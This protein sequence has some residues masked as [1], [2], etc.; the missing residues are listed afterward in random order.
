MSTHLIERMI[1]TAKKYNVTIFVMRAPTSLKLEMLTFH[2][3]FAKNKR[4]HNSS[5]VMHCL[6]DN[7]GARTIGD[8]VQISS[9]TVPAVTKLGL[10][11]M[12]GGKDCRKKAK[13]LLNRIEP[14][15]KPD[16][17]TP[18]STIYGTHPGESEEIKGKTHVWH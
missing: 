12:K 14:H 5:R 9:G 16:R 3:P 2:H 6:Q 15:W 18:K 17:E 13:D 7:H 1:E 4:P 10:H 8:P 11:D